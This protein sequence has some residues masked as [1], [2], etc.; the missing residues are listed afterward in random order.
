MPDLSAADAAAIQ[1]SSQVAGQA[2]NAMSVAKSSKKDREF[3]EHMYQIQNTDALTNWNRQNEYNSPQAQMRRFKE[4]GLNPNLIYG[5]QN[6]AAPIKSS[7]FKEYKRTPV[8]VDPGQ[9]G[10]TV[11][12]YFNVM[13]Q[14]AEMDN[15]KKQQEVADS[16]IKLNQAKALTEAERP[17]YINQQKLASEF[18]VK[19]GGQKMSFDAQLQPFVLS[20]KEALVKDIASQITLRGIQGTYLTGKNT[21]EA[22]L[23]PYQTDKLESSSQLDWQRI[24]ESTELLPGRTREL[25]SRIALQEA[26]ELLKK[27]EI[28]TNIYTR[29]K[30]LAEA[31]Y[32]FKEVEFYELN[33]STVFKSL[34]HQKPFS[35]QTM[36]N[37]QN[38]KQWRTK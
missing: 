33:K 7:D 6:V 30:L 3:M 38:W 37:P 25:D 26:T 14:K 31:Q 11:N 20:A 5:Q 17:G 19:Y 29:K 10:D 22:A 21:R 8:T 2:V 28:T 36:K 34:L 4:A 12:T 13:K 1:A 27:A 16:L 15:M 23:L 24:R 35:K 32:K 9:I 18:G